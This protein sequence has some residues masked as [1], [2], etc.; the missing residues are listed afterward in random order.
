MATPDPNYQAPGTPTGTSGEAAQLLST[1]WQR[2]T[3]DIRS[4]SQV[5]SSL[6][7]VYSMQECSG[8]YWYLYM[9]ITCR[10]TLS[11]Q[12][13]KAGTD[14]ILVLTCHGWQVV[15]D[16]LE[17]PVLFIMDLMI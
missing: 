17:R 15:N 1:F 16:V 3:N 8:R 7:I 12:P 6:S 10:Q 4:M 14:I 5:Q 11:V 2:G 13:M 9:V